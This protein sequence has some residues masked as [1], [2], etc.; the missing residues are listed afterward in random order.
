MLDRPL[1]QWVGAVVLAAALG[2]MAWA[3]VTLRAHR[4]TFVPW[5][6]VDRLV[7][8]GPFAQ[9]QPD[10][11]RRCPRPPRRRMALASW[12]PLLTLPLALLA[13]SRWVIDREETYLLA[14]F[15]AQYRAYADRVRRLI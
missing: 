2:L 8:T 3:L 14:R 7:T 1:V 11:S 9:P 10:L 6:P 13:L 5:E 4:T 12:W 15:G